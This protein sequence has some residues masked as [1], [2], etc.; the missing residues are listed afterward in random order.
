MGILMK[1][2]RLACIA[3]LLLSSS[4]AIA[5]SCIYGG[6]FQTYSSSNP[7]VI[8]GKV[9]SYGPELRSNDRYF[10][11]MTIEISDVVKGNI[12]HSR[13]ELQGDTG[14]S[15]FKYISSSAY[16]IGSEHLFSLSSSEQRQPLWG[17]GESSIRI[18]GSVAEGVDGNDGSFYKIDLDELISLVR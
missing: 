1:N 17:C 10:E 13:I 14:M 18:N 9:L 16:P 6:K 5:C 3:T 4:Y 8:R 12:Q 11:T 7:V 15:C 2:L